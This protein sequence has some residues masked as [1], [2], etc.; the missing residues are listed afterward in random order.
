MNDYQCVVVLAGNRRE[1]DEWRKAEGLRK[2]DWI[3]AGSPRSIEGIC[4][5]RVVS[6]SGAHHHW[7]AYQLEQVV[8]RT[9]V[10]QKTPAEIE[11][12]P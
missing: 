1:A 4:P 7:Y 3:Y 2:Q 12:L 6:L 5:T 9:L 10:K 8:R 11:Y